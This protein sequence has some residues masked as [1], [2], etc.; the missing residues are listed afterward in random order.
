M[1][2]LLLF[3][4][5]NQT[6]SKRPFVNKLLKTEKNEQLSTLDTRHFNVSFKDA[7]RNAFLNQTSISVIIT[8]HKT[9]KFFFLNSRKIIE[10]SLLDI[11]FG[12]L[13][14][15]NF[16]ANL[17]NAEM[18][19]EIVVRGTMTT[20][21]VTLRALY[22]NLSEL[23]QMSRRLAQ[24]LGLTQF[25][26]IYIRD[27]FAD[28][29]IKWKVSV[30]PV[31]ITYKESVF[32]CYPTVNCQEEDGYYEMILGLDVHNASWSYQRHPGDYP[33]NRATAGP[34]YDPEVVFYGHNICFA[35]KKAI[36]RNKKNEFLEVC[37]FK[38]STLSRL[39]I[40]LVT[41][42][43]AVIYRDSTDV[44]HRFSKIPDDLE[45]AFFDNGTLDA[46]VQLVKDS[47]PCDELEAFPEAI[48]FG[49]SV[50]VHK[51][52]ARPVDELIF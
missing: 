48:L 27:D 47:C 29:G 24:R 23:T 44:V 50:N 16:V 32:I 18:N 35:K 43:L 26:E 38:T 19:R 7:L 21:P 52:I 31:T 3:F 15:L 41:K 45:R 22:A 37:C 5:T 4:F 51:E 36:F 28:G 12:D 33:Q 1:F 8:K 17:F 6:A 20:P 30:V 34:S 39:A 40:N 14:F 49:W 25:R 42:E 2:F 13:F 11:R 10:D 46:N 9:I